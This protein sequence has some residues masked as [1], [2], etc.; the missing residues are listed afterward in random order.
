MRT[1]LG[2][3]EVATP[4]EGDLVRHVQGAGGGRPAV[5]GVAALAA[6]GDVRRASGPQIQPPDPLV[7][8]IAEEERA[9]RADDDAV[10]VVDLPLAVTRGAAADHGRDRR[11]DGDAAGQEGQDGGGQRVAAGHRDQGEGPEWPSTSGST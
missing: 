9:V 7:V 2:D 4:I 11:G 10:G 3:V 6:A 8:E 5:A 1:T